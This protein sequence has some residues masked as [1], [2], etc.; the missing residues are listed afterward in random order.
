[1]AKGKKT[2]GRNIKPGQVLNPIGA[3]AISP[4]TRA[5]RRITTEHIEEVADVIL[6]GNLTRLAEL[7]RN[8]ESSVLKVWIAKAAAEG[9]RKGEI[10]PLE[11]ILSRVLGRP[12]ER[13]E[14]SMNMQFEKELEELSQEQLI[15]R[16]KTAIVVMETIKVV[17]KQ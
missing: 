13:I 9:I 8:P 7:A 17:K 14:A 6:E 1:M 10:G 16:V 12:K 15:D 2:G 4:Q 5:I 3:A 11:T